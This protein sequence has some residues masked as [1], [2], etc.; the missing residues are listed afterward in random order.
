MHPDQTNALLKEYSDL[1]KDLQNDN[2]DL[3]DKIQML[4]NY[5]Q[6]LE[7]QFR[8]SRDKNYDC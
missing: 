1:I 5:I 4:E 2:A 7:F 6:E 8:S 3:N